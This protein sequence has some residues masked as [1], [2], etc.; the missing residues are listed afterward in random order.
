VPGLPAPGI[1]GTED[2]RATYRERVYDAIASLYATS[3]AGA[4][5][6]ATMQ[7]SILALESAPATSIEVEASEVLYGSAD[8]TVTGEPAFTYN[9]TT[10]RLTVGRVQLAV[11]TTAA[12]NA[13]LKLTTAGAAL[14]TVAEAGA[15]E[16]DGTSLFWTNGAGARAAL[17]TG[18]WADGGTYIYPADGAAEMV[19]IGS[20]AAPTGNAFLGVTGA[21]GLAHTHASGAA[22][23]DARAQ[24]V[25][26]GG[27]AG[28]PALFDDGSDPWVLG[29]EGRNSIFIRV[30]GG[31]RWCFESTA[32]TDFD[33]LPL[34]HGAQWIGQAAAAVRGYY[35]HEGTAGNNFGLMFQ[36]AAGGKN[37]YITHTATAFDIIN[38]IGSTTIQASGTSAQ[39]ILFR[40]GAA[41]NGARVYRSGTTYRFLPGSDAAV[42]LG[43]A[44]GTAG[45]AERWRHLYLSGRVDFPIGGGGIT[46][47]QVTAPTG[48]LT[49]TTLNDGAGSG[50]AFAV[51]AGS[52][53][54]CGHFTITA[55]NGTPGVGLAGTLTFNA[56]RAATPKAVL[57][58]SADADGANN[59][60]YVTALA[61][62]GFAVNF[63]AALSTSE[64]VE[65][66]YFVVG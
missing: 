37:A 30:A 32:G 23:G 2:E 20:T 12:G 52:T 18:E 56:T 55:G 10:N 5:T 28:I 51:T 61:T 7:A 31:Y 17:A 26:N 11:G 15:I 40:F 66:Y 13:P 3:Q 33:F 47:A 14:T 19:S 50:A 35:V 64:V 48:D 16:T 63:G 29:T 46:A 22:T 21:L 44:A 57:L 4:T 27:L 24:W 65:F 9:D 54:M 1:L 62:S 53:D 39:S 42:D 43:G 58:T 45:S 6:T 36:S 60:V 59:Q 25:A 34:T 41:T 38:D 8:G 49:G